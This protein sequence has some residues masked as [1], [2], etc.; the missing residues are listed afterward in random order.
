MRIG[1]GGIRFYNEKSM[2]TLFVIGNGFDLWCGLE[3][4]FKA[5]HNY[6]YNQEFDEAFEAFETNRT[7]SKL[8]NQG[9]GCWDYLI[10]KDY[11]ETFTNTHLWAD[12]ESAIA[13][14]VKEW[15][16]FFA[17]N[18]DS[19]L[20]ISRNDRPA[21]YTV[22]G[23]FFRLEEM[24]YEPQL[25]EELKTDRGF[26]NYEKT[27]EEV[28][29]TITLRGYADRPLLD[30]EMYEKRF[31]KFLKLQMDSEYERRAS[32]LWEELSK[33]CGRSNPKLVDSFN[34]TSPR[35]LP[36]LRHINGDLT[37][38]IIGID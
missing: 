12:F 21:K 35:C 38:P 36:N 28:A 13:E 23:D 31:S 20:S 16:P 8:V 3:S 6:S 2:A 26:F 34:Y 33:K 37:N 4:T 15:E 19:L 14:F 10:Y 32:F 29:K 5:F 27:D 18:N 11:F 24:H 17:Q 9:F 7:I 1:E 30:L 25:A 22:L